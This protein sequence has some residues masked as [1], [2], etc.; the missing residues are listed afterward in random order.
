M[1]INTLNRE[2]TDHN[3]EPSRSGTGRVVPKNKSSS[4]SR[5]GTGDD[6]GTMYFFYPAKVDSNLGGV[7]IFSDT[8]DNRRHLRSYGI[9]S[10]PGADTFG[11]RTVSFVACAVD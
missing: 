4:A 9:W 10:T 2:R 6:R 5:S 3:K 11:V 7:T 8:I 1:S